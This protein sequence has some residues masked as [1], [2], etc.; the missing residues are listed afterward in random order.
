VAEQFHFDP[1]TYLEMVRSEVPDY[2]Q[3]QDI[4]GVDESDR[5]LDVAR[6]AVPGAEQLQWLTDATLTATVLWQR[7]DL[8]VL[9][10]DH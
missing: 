2:D 7:R 1:D 5:T 6:I 9:V 8:A 10:A 3:L 4:V